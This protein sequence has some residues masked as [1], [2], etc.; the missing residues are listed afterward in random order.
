M[1]K[2]F[3]LIELLV[4]IAIIAILAAML[5]PALSKARNKARTITCSNNLKQ[6]GTY[7]AFY[8]DDSDGWIMPT[9]RLVSGGTSGSWLHTPKVMGYWEPSFTNNL[10]GMKNLPWLVC[11]SESKTF[12]SYTKSLFQYSHYMR[13]TL[14]GNMN[15]FLDNIGV[16]LDAKYKNYIPQRK[17]KKDIQITQPSVAIFT[18]DSSMLNTYSSSYYYYTNTAGKHNGGYCSN[19]TSQDRLYYYNGA[20]NLLYGDGHVGTI[21]LPEVAITSFTAGF[22]VTT[23][24]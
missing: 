11:P 7:D 21:A 23:N 5:L 16:G 24:R 3:T 8:V 10:D 19:P 14:C 12:G 18:S 6:L 22:E 9:N 20:I 4:V 13:S 15:Y 2:V 1:K 17:I